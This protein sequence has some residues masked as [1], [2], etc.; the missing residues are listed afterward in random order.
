[1]SIRLTINT[2]HLRTVPIRMAAFYALTVVV[3]TVLVSFILYARADIETKTRPNIVLIVADDLGWDDRYYTHCVCTPS[4]AALL[5]GKYAHTTGTQGYPL[6]NGEDRGL[7]LSEKLLPEYLKELGYA[8]HLVGKW[9]LGLSR[10]EYLP[11]FRGFDSHFGYRG[12]VVDYYEYTKAEN[13]NIGR[14]TGFDLYRNLTP[15]WDV[16]GYLTD[17]FTDEAKKIIK[18]HDKSR[19]LFLMMAHLAPHSGNNGAL[20]QAPPEI[21]RSMRHVENAERRIFA[22]MVKKLDDSVGEI[23]TTLS[24]NGILDNSIIVFIS[25]NGGMPYGNSANYASNW[26]LRGSKFTP[27]EGGIR[28]AGLL[29]T[30]QLSASNHLWNGFMHVVDWLPTLLTAI[31]AKT[32][33]NIDGIDLW[34]NIVSNQI[35]TREEIFEIFTFGDKSFSSIT[36]G[37]YKLV[38]GNVEQEYSKFFGDD[39]RGRNGDGP[40]YVQTIKNS[41]MYSVLEKMGNTFVIDE[42]F[43]RDSLRITCNLSNYETVPCKPDKDTSCLYNI[44][45]DPCERKDLLQS[46]LEVAQK[47][48][49]R[50]QAEMKRVVDPPAL[51]YRDPRALPYLHNYTWTT[52]VNDI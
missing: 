19:P 4:R 23:V 8:T 29:W 35:S 50:L 39:V 14:V 2:L 31:G 49:A 30:S 12:G 34:N 45:E 33:D 3:V 11:T 27:F 9:H 32:P 6:T 22:A 43:L 52:W 26:P 13:W 18:D 37:D 46:H 17:I 15:A 44:R 48:A 40:S 24:E 41:N 42:I 47:L 21:I 5:T 38:S 1:M 7:P 51:L 25:D 28:A 16:E 10:N 36:Q 20:L